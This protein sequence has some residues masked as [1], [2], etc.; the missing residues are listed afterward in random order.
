[1]SL[2]VSNIKVFPVKGNPKIKANGS[3]L[4]DDVLEVRFSILSSNAGNL[5]VSFPGRYG[6]KKG[7][8]EDKKTWFSDVRV[9]NKEESNKLQGEILQVYRNFSSQKEA[10]EESQVPPKE[11]NFPF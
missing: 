11:N 9:V 10:G 8:P 5:F 3:M 7:D 2:Q 6:V 4:V 1:M